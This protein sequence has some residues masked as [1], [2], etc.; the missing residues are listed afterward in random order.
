VASPRLRPAVR[1]LILDDDNRVL[2]CRFWFPDKKLTVWAAPGGGVE[3]SEAPLAALRRELHEEVGLSLVD[4]PP[5]VWH[6]RV[7]A[8]GHAAGYDGVINDY[9]L[10]RTGHFI[11][12]GALDDAALRA[13]HVAGFRWWTLA[14][15]AD[16]GCDDGVVFSP[17]DLPMLLPEL[18]RTGA[19]EAPLPLGL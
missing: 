16:Q 9:Y 13:E 7:V 1:A 6:Q 11:P 14:E 5:H 2:L 12:Q 19:P 15:L 4:D 3:P 10:V 17:R 8:D 18:L